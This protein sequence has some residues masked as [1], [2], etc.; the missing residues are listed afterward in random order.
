MTYRSHYRTIFVR[1]NMTNV[2]I[3]QTYDPGEAEICCFFEK[4]ILPQIVFSIN[5]ARQ[6]ATAVIPCARTAKSGGVWNV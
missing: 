5:P 6:N 2:T 3:E 1:V 4:L